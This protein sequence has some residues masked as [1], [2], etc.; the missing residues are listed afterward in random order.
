MSDHSKNSGDI[1]TDD[2]VN[3]KEEESMRME[4]EWSYHHIALTAKLSLGGVFLEVFLL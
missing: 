2:A 1:E 3:Q 4:G